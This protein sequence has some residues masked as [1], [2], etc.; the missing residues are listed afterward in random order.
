MHDRTKDRQRTLDEYMIDATGSPCHELTSRDIQL[1]RVFNSAERKAS[2]KEKQG[3]NNYLCTYDLYG[4][5]RKV[6]DAGRYIT[7]GRGRE[8]WR[9]ESRVLWATVKMHE[10]IG[11]CNFGPKKLEIPSANPPSPFPR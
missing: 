5:V 8:G 4:P 3:E 2:V 10:P 6:F 7:W 1:H 11:E 9:W